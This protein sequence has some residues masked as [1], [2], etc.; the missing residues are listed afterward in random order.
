M[1][2][3][4]YY[5]DYCKP[6]FEKHDEKIDELMVLVKNGLT[7]RVLRAERASYFMITLLIA[8]LIADFFI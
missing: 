8:K 3:P 6:H 2:P 7:H 1:S 5:H 4:D